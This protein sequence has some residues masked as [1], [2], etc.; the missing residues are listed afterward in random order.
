MH[1]HVTR[2]RTRNRFYTTQKQFA[3]ATLRF[4]RE[5]IPNTGEI[6]ETRSLTTSASY[7]TTIFGVWS[8]QSIVIKEALV[9]PIL[10]RLSAKSLKLLNRPK[11]PSLSHGQAQQHYCRFQRSTSWP[12]RFWRMNRNPKLPSLR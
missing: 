1:Q 9:G 3:K 11:N 12:N 5:T 2:N 4:F 6:F 7:H 10:F 8:E